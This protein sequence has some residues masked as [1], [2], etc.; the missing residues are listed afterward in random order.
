MVTSWIRSEP[1]AVPGLPPT[2]VTV[3]FQLNRDTQFVL[4]PERR[5]QYVADL[6]GA[7]EAKLVVSGSWPDDVR[8][9]G[10]TDCAV[11]RC[12]AVIPAHFQIRSAQTLSPDAVEVALGDGR[13]TLHLVTDP[14]PHPCAVGDVAHVPIIKT[15]VGA[16]GCLTIDQ[17]T[18]RT[19]ST[20]DVEA[21]C[22][23][24]APTRVQSDPPFYQLVGED[25]Q[26][27]QQWAARHPG[28]ELA[29]VVDFTAVGVMNSSDVVP[30][31]T[32]VTVQGFRMQAQMACALS[33]I[34]P[35]RN[36]RTLL[37]SGYTVH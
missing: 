13:M 1:R 26:W 6:A 37:G 10:T 30:D 18:V 19:L 27:I 17:L 20:V 34:L 14:T 32:I 8:V 36:H 12:R 3:D 31:R 24:F 22:D 5:D 7:L 21:R 15:A 25:A 28:A 16:S 2:Q 33:T 29:L 11:E 9:T 23:T 35:G 4:H